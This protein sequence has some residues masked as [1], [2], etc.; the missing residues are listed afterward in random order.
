MET[1]KQKLAESTIKAIEKLDRIEA[2]ERTF[3]AS[4]EA[5]E[6][7]NGKILD[8]A[9][10]L[11]FFEETYK[12]AVVRGACG[13]VEIFRDFYTSGNVFDAWSILLGNIDW[14]SSE[15]IMYKNRL[16]KKLSVGKSYYE[17]G[18]LLARKLYNKKARL[19]GEY[20]RYFDFGMI[21]DDKNYK[22]DQ[23]H[24]VAVLYSM[25]GGFCR[26]LNYHNGVL[27]NK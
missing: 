12:L 2:E 23:L 20:I 17:E 25:K 4:S 22:D 3:F 26:T 14:L 18:M 13:Q 19:N 10:Q 6:L 9:G 21:S 24:G 27:I 15:R 1:I 16:P 7:R 8:R 5:I 11:A